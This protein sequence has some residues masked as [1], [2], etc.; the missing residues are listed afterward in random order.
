MRIYQTSGHP[1]PLTLVIFG[2]TGDLAHRKLLPSLYRLTQYD[3]LPDKLRIVGVTRSKMKIKTLLD[4]IGNSIEKSGEQCDPKVLQKLGKMIEIVT[5]DLLHP[6]DY[7][8]LRDRLEAIE[9]EAGVCMNRLMY[10]AIPAQVFGPVVE[11]LGQTGL[12]QACQHGTGLSR[13]LIEKPF[14]YDL[15]SAEELVDHINQQFSEEQVFRIDHYLA[16]ETV[17]NI[18]TFRFQNP[19]FKEV[20][21]RDCIKGVMITVAE[22]IDIEGRAAFYE[23]TGAMRDVMQSHMLQLLALTTMEEPKDLGSDEI[24]R[25]KAELL[26][27]V[28]PIAPNRVADLSVRGQ[29]ESYRL[30]VDRPESFVETYAALRLQIDNDR[31]AGVPILLRTGKALNKRV[32]EITVVFSG[33]GRLSQDNN[34]TIRIQPDE[35]IL[36]Q[37][38]AKKPGFVNV[39]E[40]VR[41]DFN[42]GRTFSGGVNPDA[43]DRVLMDAFRGSRTL[44]AT[45][46]EVLMSWKILENVIQEWSK[47]DSG[48]KQ[49]AK[50]SWGP[51]DAKQ[52]AANAGLA[53]PDEDV[54]M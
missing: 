27:S 33:D 44:F 19:I 14:G 24:H 39:V 34:L 6:P 29:Y 54:L 46:E 8:R 52:L 35:G 9:N 26:K 5:M 38:L 1:A 40:P 41:M 23:Q 21:H 47:S 25:R 36:L 43:Y 12:N 4:G 50:G 48:L 2:I 53:W 10:L 28:V 37:L 42:Y 17:Q 30:E 13:L 7:S 45:S 22:A 31:W 3:M 20:W 51:A 49:Y 15:T 16:K 32:A 18:L 11:R